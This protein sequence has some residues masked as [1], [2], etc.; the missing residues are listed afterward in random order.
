MTLDQKRDEFRAIAL[1]L[2]TQE[3]GSITPEGRRQFD[4][5]CRLDKEEMESELRKYQI[6]FAQEGL[7][8]HPRY[9]R[10]RENVRILCESQGV[11][12]EGNDVKL[13]LARLKEL[14]KQG[15]LKKKVRSCLILYIMC[16]MVI[17][18][19]F[20]I[21]FLFFCFHQGMTYENS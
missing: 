7:Q 8:K 17:N 18:I 1:S 5:M 20:S 14:A 19:Y 10:F 2:V 12:T 16:L 3:D 4:V 6:K 13:W 21:S 11:N 9:I 15:K